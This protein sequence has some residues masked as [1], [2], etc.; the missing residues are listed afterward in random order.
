MFSY[1][2]K[3]DH[4]FKSALLNPQKE[5]LEDQLKELKELVFQPACIC[6]SSLKKNP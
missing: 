3:E 5:E 4:E 6:P 2:C 1:Q